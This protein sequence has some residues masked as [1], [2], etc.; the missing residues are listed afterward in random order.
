MKRVIILFL[1]LVLCI[2][3]G[4]AVLTDNNEQYLDFDNNSF[5]DSSVNGINASDSGTGNTSGIIKDA[6]A[7]NGITNFV[8]TNFDQMYTETTYSFWVRSSDT[9]QGVIMG[10]DGDDRVQLSTNFGVDGEFRFFTRQSGVIKTRAFFTEAS[11]NDGNYH[12]ILIIYNLSD[13]SI[14]P[15]FDGV[16]SSVSYDFQ[17]AG[18][19]YTL[20]DEISLGANNDGGTRNAH[21]TADIDEFSIWSRA[22]TTTEIAEL[23]NNGSGLN[24]YA[25]PPPVILPI[26]FLNISVNNIT[27]ENPEFFNFSILNWETQVNSTFPNVNQ[28]YTY[29]NIVSNVTTGPVQFAT[30]NVNGSFQLNLSNGFYTM[31]IFATNNESN[32][33]QNLNF[34]IDLNPP[35]LIVNLPTEYRAYTGFNFSQYITVSDNVTG[36]ALCAVIIENETNTNCFEENYNFTTNGNKTISVIAVDQANNSAFSLNN[37]MLINPYQF[38][39]F[40]DD[41]N[42]RLTNYTFGG[43]QDNNGTV[44]FTTYND[45]IVLGNNTLEFMKPGFVRQNF[46]FIITNTSDLNITFVV[47]NSLIRVFLF[48]RTT[49]APLVGPNVTLNLV[50]PAGGVGATETTTTGSVVLNNESFIQGS[51]QLFATA[52]GYQTETLVFEYSGEEILDLNVYML[53]SSNAGSIN[54]IVKSNDATF[55]EGAV[56]KL[57]EYSAAQNGFFT[58]SETTTNTNGDAFLNIELGTKLYKFQATKDGVTTITNQEIITVDDDFR[59]LVL[60]LV[61]ND[62]PFPF[63]D[64]IY[65]ITLTNVSNNTANVVFQW[66]SIDNNL[67][68]GTIS[69][70]EVVGANR[71]TK[72][73]PDVSLSSSSAILQSGLFSTNNS[74]TLEVAVTLERNGK[75]EVFQSFRFPGNTALATS[76]EAYGLHLII[77]LALYMLGMALG[78]ALRN[79]NLAAV[80]KIVFVWS[81]IIIVPGVIASTTAAVLSVFALGELIGGYRRR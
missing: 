77:P 42:N 39:N 27:F 62:G 59:L 28:T 24:F 46:S 74:Y 69:F 65:N 19:A 72:V 52:T 64:L 13:G 35:T 3:S 29:T 14:Q 49:L 53:N 48:D 18:S 55:V 57:L 50:P 17:I 6:R 79:E 12:H 78:L 34:S 44:N 31:D 36:L 2:S 38:F 76:L 51:Y 21:V 70:Y 43:R 20:T 41:D 16:L 68:T 1:S 66:T 58:A 7:Y 11:W 22:L 71:V 56:V 30:N 80:L 61:T 67:Y 4:F 32:V 8:N 81:S 26:S 73:A 54:V 60:N 5:L 47:N 15:Y 63:D 40:D 25:T 10:V 23:Y 33:T 75:V 45:G 9:D 37:V